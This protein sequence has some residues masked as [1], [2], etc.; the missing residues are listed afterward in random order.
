MVKKHG[1]GRVFYCSDPSNGGPCKCIWCNSEVKMRS[2]MFKK[3]QI[4]A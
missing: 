3:Y 1:P 2:L 4:G